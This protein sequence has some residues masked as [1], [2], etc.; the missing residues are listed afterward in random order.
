[1][2]GVG[3]RM[4]AKQFQSLICRS[5]YIDD[6]VWTG[7]EQRPALRT[8]LCLRVFKKPQN[9]HRDSLYYYNRCQDCKSYIFVAV[10]AWE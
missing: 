1:M 7:P 8:V 9:K 6:I 4:G 3:L 2:E 10:I 5:Q